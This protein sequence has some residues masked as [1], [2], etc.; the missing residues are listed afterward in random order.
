MY[1]GKYG[2]ETA[3]EKP[4]AD[5]GAWIHKGSKAKFILQI[6]VN[7]VSKYAKSR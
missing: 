4:T 2:S 6:S 1:L 7:T 5:G 3:E